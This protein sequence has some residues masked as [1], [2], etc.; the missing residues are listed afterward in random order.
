MCTKYILQCYIRNNIYYDETR[1]RDRQK[2]IETLSVIIGNTY[3]AIHT[4][5]K[6]IMYIDWQVPCTLRYLCT[7][8][9]HII[10][11]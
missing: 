11:I 2:K 8:I 1:S 9:A 5:T 4:I 10:G 7:Y 6:R 3:D